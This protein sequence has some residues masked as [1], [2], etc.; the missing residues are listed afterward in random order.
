MRNV[1]ESVIPL[2][3][4]RIAT[5]ALLL[6]NDRTIAYCTYLT[7]FVET[8]WLVIL[9]A[10]R[11][12]IRLHFKRKRIATVALL[13]RNDRTIAYCTYL[14]AFVETKWLVILSAKRERIR[15]HFKRKRIATAVYTAS[16]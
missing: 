14:T 16:Q 6:R 11:E 9:S 12:R 8:K 1:K 3:G 10:K 2:E 5:V 15:L 13:L 7:A 4:E